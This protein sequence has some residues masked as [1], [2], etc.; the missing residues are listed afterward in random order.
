M[1]KKLIAFVM[2]VMVTFTVTGCNEPKDEGTV[3]YKGRYV[4]EEVSHNHRIGHMGELYAENNIPAFIDTYTLEKY[5]ED[6]EKQGL[7]VSAAPSLSSLGSNYSIANAAVSPTGE[8]FISYYDFS[9]SDVQQYALISA[10]GQVSTLSFNQEFFVYDYT[11]DGR[12]FACG[13]DKQGCGIYEIDTQRQKAQLLV[14]FE[15]YVQKLDVVGDYVIAFSEK[16]ICFYD[17]KN[18]TVTETPEA[19]QEFMNEQG[20]A[21]SVRDICSGED[22]SFYILSDKGLY[23]Y[24]MGGN[25]V[26]QL[27]DGYSC[28]IGN[29]A[30]TACSVICSTDESFLISYDDGT[31]M[32][33]R[34]D[35]DA[36]NEITSTLK[37]YSLTENDTLSQIIVEYR[38]QNPTVR[39]DY[40]VGMRGGITYDDAIKNLTTAILSGD[41]PDVL[42]LDGLDIDNYIEKNMLLDLSDSESQWNPDKVLL[43]NVAKW[44][45]DGG[46]YSVAAKFQLFGIVGDSEVLA[47]MDSVADVADFTESVRQEQGEQ[48]PIL[49]LIT[50]EKILDTAL[51]GESERIFTDN[52]INTEYLTALLEACRRIYENDYPD[53]EDTFSIELTNGSSE[54]ATNATLTLYDP[55]ISM[56]LGTVNGFYNDLNILTSFD[57]YQQPNSTEFRFGIKKGSTAFVPVCNLGITAATE[58]KEGAVNFLA[59]AVSDDVQKAEMGDGFPVNQNT[60]QSFYDKN[61]DLNDRVTASSGSWNTTQ[62][63]IFYSE[64]M[65]N[66]EVSEFKQL[67]DSLDTPIHIDTM[68]RQI[69]IDVGTQCLEG[70]LTPEEAVTEITRQLDLR[71][72]E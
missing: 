11:S 10:E 42:M 33:Y 8:Y 53:V 60:L 62:T 17:C 61:K 6:T 68:T 58:N 67:L 21:E 47:D 64:W 12:L 41:A 55:S 2:A 59:C 1:R 39:V 49:M 4:E 22:G 46:L 45:N 52:E 56:S 24:V 51:I 34:Y 27:I 70:H 23:R 35:P 57:T 36:V 9:V 71:M 40:E 54:L 72:K 16:E 50:A 19:I 44:N 5:M 14:S 32:R 13:Y 48:Y 43:D 37:V 65:N 38:M 25:M 20:Y 18:E 28:R 69:I 63:P 15:N 26:E 30:Y 29:P 31:I 7:T 66:S 3:T